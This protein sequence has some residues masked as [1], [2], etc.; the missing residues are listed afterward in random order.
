MGGVGSGGLNAHRCVWYGDERGEEDA[1]RLNT[2]CVR[3]MSAAL[4][5]RAVN[6]LVEVRG[7]CEEGCGHYGAA[8]TAEKQN[9]IVQDRTTTSTRKQEQ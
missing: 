4:H 6:M 3:C 2:L 9:G 1:R 7:H 5:Q 8:Q